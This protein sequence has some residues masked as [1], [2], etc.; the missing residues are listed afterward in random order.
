MEIIK[1]GKNKNEAILEKM[2]TACFDAMKSSVPLVVVLT[3]ED[4]EALQ[5][6]RLIFSL[7]KYGI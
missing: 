4:F 5:K 6:E 2:K 7:V 3:F 1:A